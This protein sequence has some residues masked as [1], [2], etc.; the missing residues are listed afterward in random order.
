MLITALIFIMSSGARSLA[1]YLLAAVG[2]RIIRFLRISLFARIHSLSLGY[3]T[4]HEV[5]DVMSRLTND[6]DTMQQ[7]LNFMLVSVLLAFVTVAWIVLEMLRLNWLFGMISLAV[8]PLSYIMTVWLST[9]ARREFRKARR[10]IGNINADLQENI[11]GV[12]EMQAFVREGAS[13]AAFKEVN[14]AN[15]DANIAAG[16]L[17]G[18]P[19]SHAGGLGLS[20]SG[21]CHRFWRLHHPERRQS[22]RFRHNPGS[23]HHLHQPAAA[24]ESAHCADCR[25]VVQRTERH[26]RGGTGL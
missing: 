11:T 25:D 13:S 7:N 22:G 26:C 21:H 14:A 17:H 9:Q 20:G 12:R 10:E 8:M 16:G 3:F 4:R 6:L 19:E 18:G 24:P 23:A 1:F 5:G 15:R 2:N